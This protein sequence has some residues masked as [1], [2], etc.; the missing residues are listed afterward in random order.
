MPLMALMIQGCGPGSQNNKPKNVSDQKGTIIINGSEV[1]Y[2][3]AAIWEAE[4]NKQ[5]PKIVIENKATGS[6]NSLKLLEAGKIQIAMVSRKLTEQEVND[7]LYVVPVAMD[8]V[9]P[10]ISFGNDHIQTIAQKGISAKKLSGVFSGSIKTWGQL[11]GD[12]S[13]DDIEVFILPDS[14]GT[15]HS[16]A[17][18]LQMDVKKLKGN[19]MYDNHAMANTV[20]GKKSGIGYCSM[21]RIYNPK[22]NE[23]MG[24]IY[25]IPVDLNDNGQADDNE[26][27]FDKLDI[28]KTAISKGKYPSPPVRMLYLVTKN[29]P[30]DAALK[31]FLSWVLGI[32]QNYCEP[33]GLVNINRKVA[34]KFLKELR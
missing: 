13:K 4:F 28:L 9:L 14:T 24:D 33:S 25:V 6:D 1:L 23:R 16:W 22:T 32:G 26:L 5:F 30:K 34:E 20:A 21:S 8:A 7:G 10:V 17:D 2:P 31:T 18:F 15:S 27:V 3:L 11:L 29:P 19:C 12:K